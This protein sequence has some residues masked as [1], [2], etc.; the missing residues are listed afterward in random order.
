MSSAA[1]RFLETIDQGKREPVY[2]VAGDRVLAEPAAG[3]IGERLARLVDC[4]VEIYRRPAGLGQILADLKTFSLFSTAKIIV[5]VETAV[6][7]DLRAA[8]DL[9][10]SALESAPEGGPDEVLGPEERRGAGLLLQ[11]L[12]LFH[13]DTDAGSAEGV[14]ELLP[15]WA[16]Q[17][18]NAHRKRHRNR[19]RGRRQ[20][21][22][23]RSRLGT[24][25][26]A[27]R[28]EGL[29]G[30][31]EGDLQE[32]G[33]VVRQGLPDG[34]TL[35]LA[36]SVV[37][38]EH[39]VV[40][41]LEEKGAFFEVGQVEA[42]RGGGWR[43]LDL[44]AAELEKESN[45]GIEAEALKELARRT[46]Q[47]LGGRSAGGRTQV[48]AASTARL[49]AEYRKLANLAEG[50]KIGR[51]LVEAVV[52]DRGEEDVW[53]ILD[54]I[55]AGRPGAALIGIQRLLAAAADP[56]AARLSLFALLAS[57]ARQLTAIQGMLQ[58]SQAPR[59]ER[60]YSRFKSRIAPMLQGDL[61]EGGRNPLAGVHPYRLHR[62]Y[63]AA[64]RMPA[65][66]VE[67]LPRQ[68]L[69]AEMQMKGE[70]SQPD[71]ALTHLVSRLAVES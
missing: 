1:D 18:G 56:V 10:D 14:I 31:A 32:L 53:E 38:R 41:T 13:L 46:I 66:R 52:E 71:V 67:T 57:F 50:G 22:E 36:E 63:L 6:L 34:H 43:G 11:A 21:E 12:H 59:G 49:A 16:V 20:V 69:E 8:A 25:L 51:G 35:I 64:C 30:W 54:A 42:E 65:G 39:P 68:I 24:L 58:I 2:L 60:N 27:A 61:P 4:Q 37:A 23:V 15:E 3:R 45:V 17:G 33:E 62:A 28:R 26:E 5:A 19:P 55:G 29:R 70:S 9:L 7:A 40:Q 48:E 44:L 47:R